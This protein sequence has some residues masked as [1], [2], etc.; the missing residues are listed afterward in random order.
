ML[1]FIT[2]ALDLNNIG[3]VCFVTKWQR[4]VIRRLCD[5]FKTCQFVITTHSPQVIGQV[6][7]KK[8]RLLSHDKSGKVVLT[9]ASQAFGMDSSWVLQNIMGVPARDYE[10]EQELSKV[11]DAIDDGQYEAART[12]AEKMRVEVGDF[13]DLQEAF[14]LL[15]RF[16]LLRQE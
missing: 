13:P 1:T 16:E 14:A 8:L 3:S 15:D 4:Q 11:F 12:L 2:I 5:V 9:S 7:A 10:T 6:R